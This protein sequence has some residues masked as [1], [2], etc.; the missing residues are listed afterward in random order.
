MVA[1]RRDE[2]R[3][4][5]VRVRA[6]RA[7]RRGGRV[8]DVYGGIGHA[9]AAGVAVVVGGAGEVGAEARAA[10]VELAAEVVELAVE[11]VVLL[12]E[13]ADADEGGRE[14]GDLVGGEREHAL[15]LGDGAFELLYVGLA[16]GAVAGL[17]FGVPGTLWAVVMG[18]EGV[19]VGRGVGG[20][21]E[22]RHVT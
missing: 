4:R 12:L 13:L 7:L 9:A 17:G 20:R 11:E 22:G 10:E 6:V 21:S 1:R 3:R 14:G 8:L 18:E 5:R 19:A 15:Q 16:L 2:E